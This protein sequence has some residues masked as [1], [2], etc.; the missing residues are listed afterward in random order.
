[1]KSKV[2][3]QVEEEHPAMDVLSPLCLTPPLTVGLVVEE[4]HG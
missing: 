1:M 4:A 2:K 3:T